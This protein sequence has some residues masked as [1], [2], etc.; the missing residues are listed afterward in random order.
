MLR[1]VFRLRWAVAEVEPNDTP[2]SPAVRPRWP[3]QGISCGGV[4]GSAF[5][6]T[7]FHVSNRLRSYCE[8]FRTHACAGWSPKS[9]RRT[10]HQAPCGGTSAAIHGTNRTTRGVVAWTKLHDTSG[11]CGS[12]LTIVGVPP[13]LHSAGRR[14]PGRATPSRPASAA[15]SPMFWGEN[16]CA[17]VDVARRR[18][19][20]LPAA[21]VPI[22]S[23]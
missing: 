13:L 22:A 4:A 12:T 17:L 1:G 7:G 11:A 15:L 16:V 9:S 21:G 3:L 20:P 14:G 19:A 2:M 23:R 8:A 10:A 18:I 6:P 5:W